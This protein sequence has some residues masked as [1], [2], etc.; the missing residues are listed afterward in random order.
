[1]AEVI[2]FHHALGLTD[3][4]RALADQLRTAGHVV[5]LPDLFEGRT[6]DTIREGVAH[7][8]ELGF[9]TVIERGAA[10]AEHLPDDLVYVGISLGA[11]P[12]QMLAQTRPGA[13]A[14]VL[15]HSTVPPSEFG[16]GWPEG[17]HV[18]VHTMEGD[19]WG[20]VDI[21]RA[22][23]HDVAEAEVFLYPGD[24]HLFTDHSHDDYDPD[25]TALVMGRV[26]EFLDRVG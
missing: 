26:L 7:A 18:Q 16:D 12:A 8:E 9:G 15:L 20:D 14:A 19:E 4:C 24:G 23:D 21:A 13:K 5:H 17:L 11:L 1:M 22:L 10:A 6:F 2:V 25:N 3:G